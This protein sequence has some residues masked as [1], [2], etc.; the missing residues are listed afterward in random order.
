[1]KNVE[2]DDHD[3]HEHGSLRHGVGVGGYNGRWRLALRVALACMLV[4]IAGM[5]ASA[6]MVSA[7]EA[8]VVTQFG[9]VIRVI[10]KPGLTWKAP[11][12]VQLTTRVDLRLRTTSTGL[13]DVGTRDGLRILVQVYAGWSV[14]EDDSAIRQFLRAVGNDPDEAARQL[15][16]FVGSALQVVAS[17][18]D[19][20]ELVNTDSS[21][22][23]LT[24][25]EA[26]L[27]E[28][29]EVQLR[30]TYGIAV[31]EIGIE[32][33]T[34]PETTLAV[35]V[36]RM[37]SERETV[38][39]QRTAES[40]RQAG[41]IR[42][43]AMRDQRVTVAEANER[44][45]EIEAAARKRSAEIYVKAYDADPELYLLLRSLDTLGRVVGSNTHLLLRTDAA[46]FNLLV[47]VRRATL[48][49]R[50]LR[51]HNRTRGHLTRDRRKRSHTVGADCAVD[52][53]R[54]SRRP[55]RYCRSCY[56]MGY[57]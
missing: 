37:R 32:R 51:H 49:C 27:R 15:R 52:Q 26:R 33:L 39:A 35:T 13:Q 21:R 57:D 3:P 4:A 8:I 43:A 55:F 24:E 5:A 31:A 38:V 12:P 45:A 42:S 16:S 40:Q 22:V 2:H 1:M 47:Q 17:Q 29:V 41:E 46:P 44:A 36:A 54:L 9:A 19:L 23:K 10:T 18:F 14:P 7:G 48:K 6:V 11:G 25:F 28:Q 34:L 30:A 56:R 53:R 50:R 20:A